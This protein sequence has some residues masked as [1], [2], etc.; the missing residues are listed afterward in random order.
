MR[1]FAFVNKVFTVL[2]IVV[3]LFVVIAGL[4]K[5]DLHNWALTPEDIQSLLA[6]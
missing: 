2:N 5:A 4:T 1:E 3:I 6:K